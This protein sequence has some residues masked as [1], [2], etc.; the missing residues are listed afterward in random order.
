[1][2]S[3]NAMTKLGRSLSN[4]V[5]GI[6]EIPATVIENDHRNGNGALG[7]GLVLGAGRTLARMGA[8]IYEFVTFP[9]P[10]H[11]GTFEPVLPSV[12]PW[13]QGG[14]EEYP[15]ELGYE[16][17]FSYTRSRVSKSRLP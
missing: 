7:T 4:I 6:T 2:N 14:F 8:G 17:R 12:A 16:S 13:V 1:M 3:Q 11:R 10:T 5:F 15:P 9:V